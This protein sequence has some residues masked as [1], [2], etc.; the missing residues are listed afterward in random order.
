MN[1]L[2]LQPLGLLA[3]VADILM[4]PIMHIVSL[5]IEKPQRTHR[6]NNAKLTS[7]D[8]EFLA[9]AGMVQCDGVPEE[10]P[11]FRLGIPAFHV[12]I[13]GGWR[14]YVVLEPPNDHTQWHVGW[15]ADDV[16]GV[17]QV[18]VRGPV[19]VLLGPGETSFFGVTSYVGMQMR[20]REIGRGRIGDRGPHR[21]VPLL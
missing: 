4:V 3:R 5:S 10:G 9:E 14:N 7:A 21:R 19:R 13:F 1:S 8:V 12:P 11:R 15:V 6:W 20:L 17:L 2:H 18:K 16:I